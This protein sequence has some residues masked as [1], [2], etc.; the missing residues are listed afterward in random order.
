[1]LHCTLSTEWGIG[2]SENDTYLMRPISVA[3]DEARQ[4]EIK[5]GMFWYN[6]HMTEYSLREAGV[7]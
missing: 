2:L 1:M 3:R 5:D 6:G 4:M 7:R